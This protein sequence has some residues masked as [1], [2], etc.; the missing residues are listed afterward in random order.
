VL[1]PISAAFATPVPEPGPVQA[2]VSQPEGD[3]VPQED[4]QET[5]ESTLMS[6]FITSTKAVASAHLPV[7]TQRLPI[8]FPVMEMHQI[9]FKIRRT[10]FFDIALSTTYNSCAHE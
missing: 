5:G 6:L 9:L 4:H 8:W 2:A 3:R 7:T 10:R 1:L